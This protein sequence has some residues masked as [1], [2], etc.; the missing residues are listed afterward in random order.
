MTTTIKELRTR[1]DELEKELKEINKE[2]E[3]Y[4]SDEDIFN[5]LCIVSI[6]NKNN[7]SDG[8]KFEK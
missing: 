1:A 3:I 7:T 6:V 8:W 5:Q 2:L 4:D